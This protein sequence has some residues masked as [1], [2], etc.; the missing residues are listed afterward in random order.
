MGD[1]QLGFR[2]GVG[3]QNAHAIILEISE[4]HH[5]IKKQLFVCG[6]DISKVFDSMLHKP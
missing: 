5:K 4:H 2:S 6:V 1:Q 3:V